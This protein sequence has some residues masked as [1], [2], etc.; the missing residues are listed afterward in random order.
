MSK[1]TATGCRVIFAAAVL[2]CGLTATPASGES[3]EPATV[4]A[5][6]ADLDHTD[7]AT[8]ERA[9]VALVKMGPAVVREAASTLADS[10]AIE[11][12]S[13][14]AAVMEQLAAADDLSPRRFSGSFEETSP[15]EVIEQLRRETGL[16]LGLPAAGVNLPPVTAT[17]HEA[18]A[19]AVL[20]ELCRDHGW[21]ASASAAGGAD[22]S[23]RLATGTGQFRGPAV[24]HGP[25]LVVLKSARREQVHCFVDDDSAQ[26]FELELA[27]FLEPR[28]QIG[29]RDFTVE[30]TTAFD[31]S[32]GLSLL[33][34]GTALADL[35][36]H[37]PDGAG[38]APPVVATA[39]WT[40]GRLPITLDLA[41][42]AQAGRLHLEGVVRGLVGTGLRDRVTAVDTSSEVRWVIAGE[43]VLI[44]LHPAPSTRRDGPE[45]R[46]WALQATLLQETPRD[47]RQLIEASLSNLTLQDATGRSF[48]RGRLRT[49]S[50]GGTDGGA[51]TVE[52]LGH[53]DAVPQR[54]R[55]R[56]PTRALRLELPF[57]FEDVRVP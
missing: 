14:L 19:L 5:L 39:R 28:F 36:E 38:L 29:P 32:S 49:R 24:A 13:R 44:S 53:V 1:R 26:R 31:A 35:G 43:P 25:G 55:G 54:V 34:A 41:P 4:R 7:W 47:L 10:P 12:Q 40:A 15:A 17:F 23:I 27:A 11:Q 21:S 33:P 20:A 56:M 37:L 57:A 46:R 6:I 9:Q 22:L 30:V 3:A 2:S 45:R 42:P 48:T 8:R 52:F 18:P 51:V 50:P 16:A